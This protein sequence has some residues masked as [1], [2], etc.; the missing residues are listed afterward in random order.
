MNKKKL[1]TCK[2]YSLKYKKK[3]NEILLLKMYNYVDR[4]REMY[5]KIYQL[6]EE[7][8]LVPEDANHC[9]RLHP[10]FQRIL[11][12]KIKMLPIWILKEKEKQTSHN[13]SNSF[14]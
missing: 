12:K 6:I 1:Y 4:Y 5:L 7:Y 14:H 3:T 9:L 11:K 13:M 2:C 10:N 8:V